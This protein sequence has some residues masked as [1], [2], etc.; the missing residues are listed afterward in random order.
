MPES[1]AFEFE[2]A[3]QPAAAFLASVFVPLTAVAE[4][5]LLPGQ[6]IG[7]LLHALM[8]KG[9]YLDALRLMAHALPTRRCSGGAASASWSF[10]TPSRCRSRNGRRCGR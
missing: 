2:A 9:L 6:T 8:A 5:H 4:Q 1:E 10:A 3:S 7:D